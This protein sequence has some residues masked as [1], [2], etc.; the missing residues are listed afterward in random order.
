MR[1]SKEEK[2][3]MT[4]IIVQI[5]EYLDTERAKLRETIRI[6]VPNKDGYEITL[7]IPAY[8]ERYSTENLLIIGCASYYFDRKDK[9]DWLHSLQCRHENAAYIINY[10][11]QIKSQLQQAIIEQ[12]KQIDNI[13]NFTL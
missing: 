5:N 8:R 12:N 11:T 9:D 7:V 4:A 1:Y 13:N 2:E 3:K 10:W 6:R